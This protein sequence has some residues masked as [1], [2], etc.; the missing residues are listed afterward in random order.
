MS[1]EQ[2]ANLEKKSKCPGLLYRHNILPIQTPATAAL[3]FSLL[4]EWGIVNRPVELIF[5]RFIFVSNK[6]KS[7]HF[8]QRKYVLLVFYMIISIHLRI[9]NVPGFFLL[10]YIRPIKYTF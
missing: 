4:E 10:L 9:I 1:G 6:L 3:S 7:L 8:Y 2:R 5:L